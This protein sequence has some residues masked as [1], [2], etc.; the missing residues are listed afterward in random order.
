MVIE[1]SKLDF[2][3]FGKPI[4]PTSAIV[5]SCN[6]IVNSSPKVPLVNFLG[7]L[8]VELLNLVFPSP[9]LPQE[10]ATNF[11]FGF[12]NHRLRFCSSS[13]TWF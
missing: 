11:S 3:A 2:S 1:A 8:F 6:Q 13:K 4:I 7:A 10:A 5:F 9:P 12:V